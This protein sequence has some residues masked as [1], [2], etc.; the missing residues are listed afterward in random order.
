MYQSPVMSNKKTRKEIGTSRDHE[1][2]GYNGGNRPQGRI[3]NL[4]DTHGAVNPLQPSG[5]GARRVENHY[6]S[7]RRMPPTVSKRPLLGICH[8]LA[9]KPR[10]GLHCCIVEV[11][12]E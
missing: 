9:L 8:C 10:N 6:N 3:V 11:A 7:V 5:F 4:T 1:K 12:D 2:E